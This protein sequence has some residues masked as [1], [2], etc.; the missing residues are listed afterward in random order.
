M[1]TSEAIT[2]STTETPPQSKQYKD[3]R[4]AA[5]KEDPE[6]LA[7]L[8]E[9]AKLRYEAKKDA[10]KQCEKI[11]VVIE[12]PKTTTPS[13]K[14]SPE[15]TRRY[16]AT[17]YNNHKEKVYQAKLSYISRELAKED[18]QYIKQR[19]E[20]AR[21]YYHE[22]VKHSPEQMEKQRL[23]ARRQNNMPMTLEELAQKR[24]SIRDYWRNKRA[25]RKQNQATIDS[26]AS[27]RESE[28]SDWQVQ[29]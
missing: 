15:A 6:A 13:K 9:K 17:Y 3:A 11:G 20:Y 27:T 28:S 19:R 22:V 18:S 8:R 7:K 29:H 24:I 21:T 4:Y 14:P 23:R 16:N 12:R 5:I 1:N 2:I 26:E 10:I 25:L